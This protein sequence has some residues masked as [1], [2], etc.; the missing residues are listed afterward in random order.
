MTQTKG[1]RQVFFSLGELHT[2]SSCVLCAMFYILQIQKFGGWSIPKHPLVYGLE[3]TELTEP[4][5]RRLAFMF[6]S[7]VITPKE[8][9]WAYARLCRCNSWLL[10]PR[11]KGRCLPLPSYQIL[12]KQKYCTEDTCHIISLSL[13]SKTKDPRQRMHCS[14]LHQKSL[15]AQLKLPIGHCID[16]SFSLAG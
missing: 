15:I 1:H 3:T 4:G 16:F 12:S 2:L 6:H 5:W 11:S 13:T 7:S 10:S 14:S 8:H 9:G